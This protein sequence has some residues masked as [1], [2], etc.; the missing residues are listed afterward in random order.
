MCKEHIKLFK[1]FIQWISAPTR[2]K[3]ALFFLSKKNNNNI[4]IAKWKVS[5]KLCVV[6]FNRVRVRY[7]KKK[8]NLVSPRLFQW[9]SHVL[10]SQRTLRNQHQQ[11]T[12]NVSG[13][14][15]GCPKQHSFVKRKGTACVWGTTSADGIKSLT[16]AL[17]EDVGRHHCPPT[18]ALQQS[19]RRKGRAVFIRLHTLFAS[20]LRKWMIPQQFKSVAVLPFPFSFISF[21]SVPSLSHRIYLIPLSAIPSRLFSLYSV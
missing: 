8:E 4:R 1:V 20:S 19:A 14:C 2:K 7:S 17:P 13:W 11:Q 18:A 6:F 9:V 3:N 15:R 16:T 5:R 12:L 10:V 21:F